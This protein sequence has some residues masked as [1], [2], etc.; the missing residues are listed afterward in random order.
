MIGLAFCADSIS[1][2]T[3]N[4]SNT[5]HYDIRMAMISLE[6][7]VSTFVIFVYIVCC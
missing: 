3:K 6:E 5:L 2:S 7:F 4:M 1:I